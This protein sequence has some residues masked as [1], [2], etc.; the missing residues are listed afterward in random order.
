MPG[1]ELRGRRILLT[2]GSGFLGAALLR[3]CVAEGAQVT[4]LGRAAPALPGVTLAEADLAAPA[5]LPAVL[6]ALRA[7]PRFDALLHLA[8]SRRHRDFPGGAL[9]MFRVNAAAA[10]ELLAFA[11]EGHAARAVFGSTGTVHGDA[12]PGG[13]PDDGFVRPSSYFAATKLFADT[14]C[15]LYRGLLPIAVL[16]LHAPYG[17]G[18]ADRMLADLAR[19]VR[20]GRAIDLPAEGP[21]LGFAATFVDDAVAV[22]LRALV[23][24]WNET[25]NVAAPEAWT[26]ESAGL[27]L[28]EL[29]GR[30]PVF[31]RGAPAR[32]PALLPDTAR[33]GAL[34]PGHAF[35][36]LREGLAAML[37]D[38]DA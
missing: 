8:V 5:A 17:P 13:S 33:L 37:G 34:M 11:A 20:Q 4:V 25:V 23:E 32:P 31:A 24:G 21:G 2:G 36:G 7:G 22:A 19:R 28:G 18:L 1:S 10:A 12:P 6:A 3:H 38:A 30:A 9:D 16:R 27:L 14:L 35:T 26:I 29:L 15:A